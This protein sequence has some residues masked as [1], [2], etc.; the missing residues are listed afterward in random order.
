MRRIL[1][2]L[3]ITLA[4]P[5]L[6]ALAPFAAEYRVAR[7]DL[8]IADDRFTLTRDGADSW[9]LVSETKPY[10]LIAL[11]RSDVITETSAFRFGADGA[12][13]LSYKYLHTGTSKDRNAHYE[14][15]WTAGRASGVFRGNPVDLAIPHGTLD[16]LL[17]RIAVGLDLGRD[18]IEPAYQVVERRA[19]REYKLTQLPAVHVKVLAGEFDVVGV[20][21]VSEDGKKTTR[22]LYAPSLDWL[23][24]LMEQREQD[25]ATITLELSKLTRQ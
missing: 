5:A 12:V 8:H 11:L 13:P 21:R 3:S 10:G 18:A 17:L 9:T 19:L 1:L 16:P 24:V 15:D 22:F 4:T 25:E 2:A 23:P 14:F 6:A 7:D 20:E